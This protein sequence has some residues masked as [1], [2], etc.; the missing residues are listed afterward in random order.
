MKKTFLIIALISFIGL[1]GA[2]IAAQAQSQG[3]ITDTTALE[4]LTTDMASAANLGQTDIGNLVAS[5]IRIVL[6]FLGIIFLVLTIVAGFRWMTAGGNE[7]QI[8]K[9]QGILQA[10]LIGLVIVLMAYAITYFVFKY[11]PVSGGGGGMPNPK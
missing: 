6:G 5:I 9:A 7:E 10:A 8:K 3:L 1:S 2:I 11:L 4:T